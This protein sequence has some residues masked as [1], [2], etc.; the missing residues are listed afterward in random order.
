MSWQIT[1][2]H[3]LR[4]ETCTRIY[5]N[6]HSLLS[7]LW[8]HRLVVGGGNAARADAS[9]ICIAVQAVANESAS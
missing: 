7:S 2:I 4:P 8:T 3:L 1:Y 5:I 9:L 6:M